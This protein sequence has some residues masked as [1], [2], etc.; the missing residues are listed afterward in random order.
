MLQLVV[1]FH[2]MLHFLLYLLIK[3]QKQARVGEEG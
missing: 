2:H 1:L 3:Q